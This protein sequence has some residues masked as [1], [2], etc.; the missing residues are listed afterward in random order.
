MEWLLDADSPR[1]NEVRLVQALRRS[2]PQTIEA[3]SS[4][5]GL[6]WSQVFLALDRLSR[7]GAI[8]LRPGG[9]GVYTA[10][11]KGWSADVSV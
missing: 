7:S 4:R 3:L 2:G 1:A 8:A 11:V 6:S 10:F 5:S 9:P